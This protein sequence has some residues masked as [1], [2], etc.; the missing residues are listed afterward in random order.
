MQKGCSF[1]LRSETVLEGTSC[2]ICNSGDV[3][4][5]EDGWKSEG[6]RFAEEGTDAQRMRADELNAADEGGNLGSVDVD[7]ARSMCL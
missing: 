1:G 3:R 2:V 5:V 4:K 7:Q 6:S